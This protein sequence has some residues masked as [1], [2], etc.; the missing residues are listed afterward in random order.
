MGKRVASEG[1]LRAGYDP[2][3]TCPPERRRNYEKMAARATSGSFPAIL[4]L[5]CLE[6]CAWDASEVGRCEIRG[7]ALWAKNRKDITEA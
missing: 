5:K 3:G 6:C 1:V 2:L 4:R 7:C